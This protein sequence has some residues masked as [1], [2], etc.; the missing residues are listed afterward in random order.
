LDRCAADAH[1]IKFKP[2]NAELG[3]NLL[4]IERR[5]DIG[6]IVEKPAWGVDFGFD[7]QAFKPK[8]ISPDD[9]SNP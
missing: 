4:A 2:L 1:P 6:P 5:P 8:T 9:A 7:M 3:P